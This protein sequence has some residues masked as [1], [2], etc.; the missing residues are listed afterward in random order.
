MIGALVTFLVLY[1]LLFWLERSRTEVDGF[2]I[3]T[4]AA[5]PVMLAVVV[6]IALGFLF[7]HPLA[8]AY[9]PL[10]AM[11]ITTIIL[12]LRMMELPAGRS[13]AYTVVVLVLNVGLSLILLQE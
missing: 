4:V 13:A 10:V 12:L 2:S 3:A 5:A 7:P 9:L 8:L 11:L 6:K 1:A